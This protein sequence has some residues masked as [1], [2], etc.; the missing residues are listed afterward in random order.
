[1]LGLALVFLIKLAVVAQLKDHPLLQPDAGL[2]TTAYVD[3]AKRVIGGD[4]GLGP[5]LYYVSPFY[6]YFLAIA[7]GL[8]RSFTA[9]RVIQAALG[10]V[11][12]ACVFVMAREWFGRRAAWIAAAAAAACG[13]MTF[14]EVLILQSAVDGILTAAALLTLTFALRG[15]VASRRLADVAWYAV[16]GA[17]FGLQTLN[18][19]NVLLPAVALALLLFILRRVRPALWLAAGIAIGLAPVAIRNVVVA[20][21]WS[22]VSSH[23][24]LNFYIGNHEGATGFYEFVPGVRPGIEGQRDDTRRVAEAAVGHPLTDAEVS[25]YFFNLGESW[26]REHPGRAVALFARKFLYVF[27]ADHLPLP[28]SYEFFA[29]DANTALRWLVANPWLIVPFGLVGFILARPRDYH[30]EFFVWASFV[31]AYAAAVAVFFVAER[32]RVPMFVPLFVGTG[33]LV[34][35]A[36]QATLAPDAMSRRW[37]AI[38]GAA[39]LVALGLVRWPLAL[40]DSREGDRVRMAMRA[41]E[42]GRTDEGE[43]WASLAIQASTSPA[44]VQATIGHGLIG[45]NQPARALAYLRP[46]GAS[47]S[48]DPQVLV[49]LAAALKGTGDHAAAIAQLKSIVF[50][51]GTDPKVRLEAGRL[52]ATMG[53]SELAEGVFRDVVRDHPESAD[54]WA[55]L[56][57]TLLVRN[58][59]AD[60]AQALAE[61]VRLNPRDPIALGGLAV[62]DLKLGRRDDALAHATQALAIDPHEAL[63]L[64]VIAALKGR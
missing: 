43:H 55:Q 45:A 7:Y 46:A 52:A 5:G 37:L 60:A 4:V 54:A 51:K 34:D 61:A 27:H 21:E 33:A 40:T 11:T 1:M 15:G 53:E 14:Y 41:I 48:R 10:A 31:P 58:E 9:V 3:L 8:T 19:P 17:I 59:T 13:V 38:A 50:P 20:H 2:D 32:Y 22:L 30:T 42:A 47:S 12:V 26:A 25:D 35:R 44:A 36:I 29:V 62:C 6:V 49:D 23:G 24:G 63:S 57:V 64:Q 28:S 18:R 56:G 16:A 39:T